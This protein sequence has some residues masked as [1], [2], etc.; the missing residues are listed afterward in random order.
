MKNRCVIFDLDGTLIDS[1][2]DIANAVNATRRDFNL[3]P[4]SL[5]T[6]VSYV[7]DGVRKLIYR[8]FAGTDADLEEAIRVMGRH[9]AEH[10]VVKTTLYPGVADGIRVLSENGWKLGLVSNKPT[11]LCRMI[12][13]H[14]GLDAFFCE[15]IGGSSGFPL[16][17]APEALFHILKESGS[18]ASLSWFCGDNHTDMNAARNGGMRSAYAAYGFGTLGFVYFMDGDPAGIVCTF[19]AFFTAALVIY[20]HRGNIKRLA[21]HTEKKLGEKAK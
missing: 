20:M 7:G 3:P 1:R 14:F 12:F 10:A 2:E 15:I 4:L 13:R 17:P 9:Y 11:E 21:A 5:E 16:K 19:I 18:D 8:S 6:V